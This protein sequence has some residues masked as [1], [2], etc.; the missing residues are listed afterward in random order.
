MKKPLKPEKRCKK[1]VREQEALQIKELE[2][3]GMQVAFPDTKP[4]IQAAAPV[5]EELKAQVGE[6]DYK[7][8]MDLLEKSRK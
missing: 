3:N 8:F 1:I 5:Y 4:F 7:Y 2:K 6:A